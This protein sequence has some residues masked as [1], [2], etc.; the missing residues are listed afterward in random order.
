MTDELLLERRGAETY[1]GGVKERRRNPIDPN[2]IVLGSSDAS[3][4]FK[5]GYSYVI[6]SDWAPDGARSGHTSI[7]A[8][9]DTG[10]DDLDGKERSH[11]DEDLSVLLVDG[12]DSDDM[13]GWD[14]C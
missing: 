12:M 7:E 11:T 3:L 4:S 10:D 6:P 13:D 1:G 5:E 8:T 2:P 14:R 9:A